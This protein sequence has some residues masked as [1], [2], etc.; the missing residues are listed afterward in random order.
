MR[1]AAGGFGRPFSGLILI[2]MSIRDMSQRRGAGPCAN[3][4]HQGAGMTP[5]ML[6]A[7]ARLGG[8]GVGVVPVGG[9]AA[10]S[11]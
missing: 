2:T 11:F 5:R 6:N 9:V 7:P 10:R 4:R 8:G 1:K 3:R